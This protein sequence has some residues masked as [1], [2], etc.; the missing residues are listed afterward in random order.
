MKLKVRWSICTSQSE[1]HSKHSLDLFFFHELHLSDFPLILPLHSPN[2]PTLLSFISH[3]SHCLTELIQPRDLPELLCKDHTLHC[4][5]PFQKSI[6]ALLL[7]SFIHR[8]KPPFPLAT[9]AVSM[10]N[11]TDLA[12][13]GCELNKRHLLWTY[14]NYF[15]LCIILHW[16]SYFNYKFFSASELFDVFSREIH[17]FTT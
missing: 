15:K 2:T 1:V 3:S 6:S 4:Q 13:L 5:L 16:D 8:K 11:P 17:Q 10:T 12:Y 7:D 9:P 14:V